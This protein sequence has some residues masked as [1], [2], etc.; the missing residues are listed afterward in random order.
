[1][2]AE[3]DFQLVISAVHMTEHLGKPLFS[4]PA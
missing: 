1:M 4:P 3:V 2:Q